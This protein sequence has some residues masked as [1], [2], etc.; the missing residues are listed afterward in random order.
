MSA[1]AEIF[2]SECSGAIFE[3]STAQNFSLLALEYL[4]RY[5]EIVQLMGPAV[6]EAREKGNLYQ[7]A[8]I[9]MGIDPFLEMVAGRPE[10]GRRKIDDALQRWARAG[11]YLQNCFAAKCRIEL[12]LYC[13]EPEAAWKALND[14]WP[15]LRKWQYLRLMGMCQFIYFTRAQCALALAAKSAGRAGLIRQAGADA[16]WLSQDITPYA[17]AFA[18]IVRAGCAALKG[19][20]PAARSLL[21]AGAKGLDAADMAI[22]AATVRWR[23]GQ[24]TLGPDGVRVQKEADAMMHAEGVAEPSRFAD[25]FVNGFNR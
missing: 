8:V 1:G 25:V 10:S 11:Y 23:L 4:G 6:A 20:L 9:G 15:L 18:S 2:R 16:K 21:D 17:H 12:H 14:E 13:G 3:T 7:Q 24:V 22:L 19:D 5:R